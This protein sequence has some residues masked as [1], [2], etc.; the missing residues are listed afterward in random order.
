MEVWIALPAQ[1]SGPASKGRSRAYLSETSSYAEQYVV[2]AA[3][4]A[5]TATL[6][7]IETHDRRIWC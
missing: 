4:E 2:N 3:F 7:F 1:G 5:S 6:D